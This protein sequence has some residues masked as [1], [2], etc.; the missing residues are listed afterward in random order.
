MWKND[1]SPDAPGRLE[2]L[3]ELVA[4]LEEFDTLDSFLEHVGLV[5]D[6][7]AATTGEAVNLMTLHAAKG[8]EFAHVFLPGWEEDLFPS[9]RSLDEGGT[10]A[11]EEERRLAYVGLTRAKRRVVISFAATRRLHNQWLQSMPSRFVDE[12]PSGVEIDV[13][14]GLYR[15]RGDGGGLSEAAF[16]PYTARSGRGPGY[17]RLRSASRERRPGAISPDVIQGRA[18]TVSGPAAAGGAVGLAVGTRVFHQKFG[19]G[20]VSAV[21]GNKLEIDFEKA[22]VKKVMDSFVEAV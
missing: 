1:K 5:M 8:L 17:D 9:R 20:L 21:D 7:D 2:N 16:S 4:A 6:R 12:L 10:A 19:Y 18:R 3:K 22:G 13:E 11:L 14:T 15:G